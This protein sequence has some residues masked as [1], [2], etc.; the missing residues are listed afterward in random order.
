MRIEKVNQAIIDEMD[1]L[2]MFGP[3]RNCFGEVAKSNGGLRRYRNSKQIFSIDGDYAHD[4]TP[5][6]FYDN[7]K[8]SDTFCATYRFIPIVVGGSIFHSLPDEGRTGILTEVR[9]CNPMRGRYSRH[10]SWIPQLGW[11]L[12]K[13]LELSPREI[14]ENI[15]DDIDSGQTCITGAYNRG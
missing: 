11:L 4:V 14:A 13:E 15:M 5:R 7:D 6:S 9:V 1:N 2:G 10:L 12:T 3:R 8:W